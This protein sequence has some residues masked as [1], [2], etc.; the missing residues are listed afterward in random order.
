MII[1]HHIINYIIT[2]PYWLRGKQNI[3]GQ[4]IA[5]VLDAKIVAKGVSKDFYACVDI[6]NEITKEDRELYEIGISSYI[7]PLENEEE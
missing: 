5:D 6:L 3:D 2:A 1:H 7:C 4:S